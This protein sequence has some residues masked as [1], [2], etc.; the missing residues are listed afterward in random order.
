MHL[1]GTLICC[2]GDNISYNHGN[3][4]YLQLLAPCSLE[5]TQ[6][7]LYDQSMTEMTVDVTKVNVYLSATVLQL[8]YDIYQKIQLPQTQ[9]HTTA[10][11]WV[12][13]GWMDL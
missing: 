5:F 3:H 10:L 2:L 1:K 4:V 6:K 7:F 13:C 12:D 11:E 9:V 8:L